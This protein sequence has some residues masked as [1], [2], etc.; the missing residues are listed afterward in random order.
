MAKKKKKTLEDIKERNSFF[1][2]MI[3]CHPRKQIHKS[4]KRAKDAK[5]H[6]SKDWE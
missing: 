3:K 2:V 5:N 4:V 6:W 1:A